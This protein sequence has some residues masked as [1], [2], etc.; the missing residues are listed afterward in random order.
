MVYATEYWFWIFLAVALYPYLGYPLC[1]VLLGLVNRRPV[2]TGTITPRVTVVIAAYNE[3]AHI[4]TTILN[5][6]DQ[7]YPEELLELIVVSDC[8]TDETDAVLKR[9]AQ[10]HPRV[11]FFRQH[12]RNGKTAAL[13]LMVARARGEIIVFADANSMY[14]PDTVRQLVAPFADP[15]VGYVTGQMLYVDP[16]GSLIGDGCSAY[17][18]YENLLRR[19]E[20]DLGSIVGVD[21]GVDAIRRSLYRPMRPDQLPDFVLPLTVVEQGYRVV[22]APDAVL[23]EETLTSE[24]SEYRMRV[25]VTLRALLALWDRRTLF[26][27]LRF[28]LFSWQLGSHKLLRYLSFLPLTVAL[29]LNWSLLQRGW[30]YVGGAVAQGVFAA[31]VVMALLGPRKLSQ[32][33]LS[34]YGF[35]FALLNAASAVAFVRFLRGQKQVL[36]QPRIG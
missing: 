3:A 34:R 2:K 20:T 30:V 12:T 13:N 21:G 9:L 17:M 1:V 36:W 33:G 10:Q 19:C 14:R 29:V 11:S 4:E 16:H 31:L 5:K 32:C 25:R 7:D 15:E 23:E 28:P 18:R 26:N 35:Y 6:L 22:Y 8:S 27:P 24:P